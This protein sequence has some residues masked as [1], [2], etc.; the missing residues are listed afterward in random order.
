MRRR[1]ERLSSRPPYSRAK[2]T[3]W[4]THWS[5]MLTDTSARRWTLRLAGAVVAALDGVVEEAVDA[6]AVVVVVLGRVDAAL[7][8]DRVRPTRRVVVREDL[9]VVAQLAERCG[10]RGAGEAGADHDH[11]ELAA[12]VGFDQL[13]VELVVVPL[14]GQRA[15]RD[16]RVEG[17]CHLGS[18]RSAL[19][20]HLT[21]SVTMRIGNS[22]L[23]MPTISAMPTAMSRRRRL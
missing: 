3:P 6:V 18:F 20:A 2:G 7:R 22:T 19:R 14:V 12:V 23:G 1:S 16:L 4:A 13:Q 21:T 11:V 10:G 15:G 17:E 5:M 8:R 9:D